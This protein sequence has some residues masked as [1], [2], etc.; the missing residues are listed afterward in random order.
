MSKYHDNPNSHLL[1]LSG[2]YGFPATNV[3]FIEDIPYMFQAWMA[4]LAREQLRLGVFF[5]AAAIMAQVPGA[6]EY[7]AITYNNH[8]NDVPDNEYCPHDRLFH[9]E[10]DIIYSILAECLERLKVG[11]LIHEVPVSL[12]RYKQLPIE[13]IQFL[14]AQEDYEHAYQ[15]V[16][17]ECLN[18][19][20]VKPGMTEIN[21]QA[22]TTWWQQCWAGETQSE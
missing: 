18:M 8:D 14:D 15:N 13:W 10:P 1:S 2:P 9:V 11:H 19:L 12:D 16:I 20:I 6:S 17:A 7:E 5:R 22:Q 21:N 3:R 4:H